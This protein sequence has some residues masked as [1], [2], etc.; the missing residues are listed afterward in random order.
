MERQSQVG[1]PVSSSITIQVYKPLTDMK[2]V[3]NQL[4]MYSNVFIGVA[5]HAYKSS[6]PSTSIVIGVCIKIFFYD[7]QFFF[8]FSEYKKF[9][10][11]ILLEY[12]RSLTDYNI[13]VQHCIHELLINTLV[14]NKDFQQLHQIL[15]YHVIADSKPL[16]S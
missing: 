15:Q 14:L 6:C 12:I 3:F 2:I 5:D 11:W 4:D 1:L 10:S 13:P 9:F 16:V 7:F 8:F